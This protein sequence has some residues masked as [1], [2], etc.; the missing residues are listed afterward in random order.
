[1]RTGAVIVAAGLSSRM[2]EF[3]PMMPFENTTIARHVVKLVKDA[4]ASPVVVVTGY[5]AEDLE[6]HLKDLEIQFV[7]NESYRDTQMFD[8]IKLGIQ[9]IAGECEKMLILPVD[10]PAISQKTFR[11]VLMIDADM[12]R[13]VYGGQPGHPILLRSEIAKALCSYQGEGGLKGAMENSAYSITNLQVDDKGVNWDVDTQKEYHELIKWNALRENGYPIRPQVLLGL[14]RREIFFT[15]VIASLIE[16]I[17][18]TGSIQEACQEMEIS[19]SKGSRLIKE[20]EKALGFQLLE[21]W[22]GGNSGGGSRMTQEARKFMQCYRAMTMKVQNATDTFFQE[23]FS[24]EILD[25]T[26]L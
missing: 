23:C 1:M 22:S 6:E 14:A 2:G 18:R 7:R 17:D 4:G 8:S 21:R 5:R 15:P 9:S 19:Y 11:Q 20:A 10:T 13:T 26:Q 16:Y 3:K 12:V 25:K 24:G